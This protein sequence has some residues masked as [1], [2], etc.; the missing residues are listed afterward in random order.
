MDSIVNW[1]HV[2]VPLQNFLLLDEIRSTTSSLDV[3]LEDKLEASVEVQD[4]ICYWDKVSVQSSQCCRFC[5]GT[6]TSNQCT[7]G[8][9]QKGK[10]YS[11]TLA[12]VSKTSTTFEEQDHNIIFFTSTGHS[13]LAL[14][15]EPH[16]LIWVHP[17]NEN[18]PPKYDDLLTSPQYKDKDKLPQMGNNITLTQNGKGW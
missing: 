2:N 14:K 13:M 11:S 12:F 7:Q 17:P 8:L 10:A 18:T 4:L 16:P 9:A 3:H 6:Q 5:M 15:C 1:N